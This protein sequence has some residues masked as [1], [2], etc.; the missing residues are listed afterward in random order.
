MEI[1]I[2]I[3]VAG[4]HTFPVVTA[5]RLQPHGGKGVRGKQRTELLP[6]VF[7]VRQEML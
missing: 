2:K 5:A 7:L 6:R 4:R 3:W 1:D